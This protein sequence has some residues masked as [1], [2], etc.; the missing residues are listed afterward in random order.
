MRNT[1]QQL[2]NGL[3]IGSIYALFGLGYTL[4]F[5]LLDVLNLAHSEVFML[6]AVVTYSLVALHQVPFLLAVPLGIAA[7]GV[8]GLVIEFVALRPLRRRGAPPIAALI[9]TIGLALVGVALVEQAK[10]GGSL[11]WLW[12]D[13]ANDVQFPAGKVPG[14][15]WHLA[16][17]TLPASKV[18]ILVL[19]VALM[20]VLGF[21]MNRTPAGRAVRAVAENPR[22]ARLLGVNVDRVITL[23]VV[24]SS[25]LAALAGILFALALNDI[26][27][28][29]G[30]DQ[31]ELRG[32]AVIVLGG[33]GSIPGTFVGGFVLGLL[34]SVTILTIGTD[35]RAVGFI[36]LFVMLILRPEG[37]L[38][39][40]LAERV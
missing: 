26:S 16:G 20:V 5:G 37:L 31:V 4:V 7:G 38:G 9:S 13:G 33:M 14:Q 19:T 11:A 36:A 10:A 23:T 15:I 2:L 21:V 25:A 1:I 18:A 17:L 22:A 12:R 35:V 27:P 29:I 30:R 3:F 34:E 39:R 28:Y 40:R 32:L 24:A 6:G 8:L